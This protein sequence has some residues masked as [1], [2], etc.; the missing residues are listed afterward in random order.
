VGNAAVEQL[1]LDIYGHLFQTAWLYAGA[2]GQIDADVGRRLAETADLVSTIWRRPDHGIWEVR[3]DP[4]H[5]TQSKMMCWIALDRA[6]QLAERGAIPGRN[7]GRWAEGREAIAAFIE[8]RC[9]AEEKRSYVQSAGAED[10]DASV[11]LGVLFGYRPGDPKRLRSTV[12]VVRRELGRGPFLYRYTGE[13]GLPGREGAFLACSF[14]MAEALARTGRSEEAASLM[15]ELVGLANEVGLYAEEIDPR[16]GAF[17]GN[18]P[19][20]LTHLSLVSA[21]VAIAQGAGG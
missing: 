17:L 4:R 12:E 8:T 7:S 13:D 18:F 21:S 14:W 16:T 3:G 6:V 20:A 9:W 5:F 1:Q 19:Q 11:L 10:L 2:G 15:D